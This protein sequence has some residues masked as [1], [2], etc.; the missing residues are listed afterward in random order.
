[1]PRAYF[2]V[3]IYDRIAKGSIATDDVDAL[4]RLAARGRIMTYISVADIDEMLGESQR[5]PAAAIRKLQ[6]AR[7]LV[8]FER[9][10]K[11]P[12]DLLA[13]AIRAYAAGAGAPPAVAT[14]SQ[15]TQ[16]AHDLHRIANGDRSLSGTVS[17]IVAEAKASKELFRNQMG[18]AREL[19][20]V[21][22]ESRFPTVAQRQVVTAEAVWRAGAAQLAESLADSL[23]LGAAFRSPGSTGLPAVRPARV[24]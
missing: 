24:A 23:E 22:I 7:D 14:H 17:A 20:L 9:L 8:G 16:I 3:Q 13:N 5:D 6:V 4:R 12:A 21:D 18:T 1:M 19:T 15:R 2:D 10:L 11:Q